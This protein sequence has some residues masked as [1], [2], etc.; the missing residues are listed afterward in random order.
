MTHF[1]PVTIV[2]EFSPSVGF[3]VP[4]TKPESAQREYARSGADPLSVDLSR[5]LGVETPVL[6]LPRPPH[7]SSLTRR[8]LPDGYI[9][10]VG[11]GGGYMRDDPELLREL[12]EGAL[13][14][15]L[16][17]LEA[18]APAEA[19]RQGGMIA[20]VIIWGPYPREES[21]ALRPDIQAALEARIPLAVGDFGFTRILSGLTPAEAIAEI[22]RT[23]R[24]LRRSRGEPDP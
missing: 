13:G 4:G 22:L 16:I 14:R 19:V 2:T 23:D 17:T 6:Y 3:G 15:R 9:V 1:T 5:A 21:F 24:E 20:D 12:S 11:P 7:R 18:D 10:F 8:D